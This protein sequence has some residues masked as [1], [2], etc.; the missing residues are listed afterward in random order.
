MSKKFS[1]VFNSIRYSKLQSRGKPHPSTDDEEHGAVGEIEWNQQLAHQKKRAMQEGE[2]KQMKGDDP[3][4]KG[5]EMIGKKMKNGKEVPNC[6]PVKEESIPYVAV[7]AKKGKHE[8]HGST[9]YEAAQNAAKHWKMKNTSGI[10]VYRADKTHSTQHVGEEVDEMAGANMDTRAVH[11][12]LKKSGWQLSRSKGGHD[13]YTHPKSSEHIAVPRHKQLKAPLVLGIMKT[14]K[15]V[16][17]DAEQIDEISQQTKQSY[18]Q[19]AKAQVKELEPHSKSGEYKDIA[20]N[21]IARR[22]AGIRKAMTESE[23]DQEKTN[24]PAKRSLSKTTAIVK[25]AAKKAKNKKSSEETFQD[26]PELSTQIIRV[27]Y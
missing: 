6:V 19:K 18:A 12:H 2:N 22:Q 17:E 24:T 10:S 4:W 13:V 16:S 11:K 14:A 1:D 25:D 5:Y 23:M 9:S 20:K 3:C 15:N 27:N 21:A 7:H 8:T 26:E